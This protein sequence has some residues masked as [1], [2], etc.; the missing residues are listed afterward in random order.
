MKH[1]LESGVRFPPQPVPKKQRLTKVGGQG[2]DKQAGFSQLLGK[3]RK[4]GKGQK[5]VDTL[6]LILRSFGLD[7]VH[8]HQFHETRRWRFDL[9]V[10]EIKL[11]I[12]YHGHSGFTGG[13]ASGH[14]TVIGLTN[15]AEKFNQARI[16][17]WTVL[18]FTT[19]HFREVDRIKRKLTS[20]TLTIEAWL[21]TNGITA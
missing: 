20:P 14:S 15:D 5:F 3:Q 6:D 12:E 2:A 21:K 7:P 16:Y 13:K 18:A 4:P 9:A 19:L 17:G 8:E 11:A 1:T 10:P